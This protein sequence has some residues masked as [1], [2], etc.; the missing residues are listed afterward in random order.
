MRNYK[1][2]VKIENL[3]NK[4]RKLLFFFI[5]YIDEFA[6]LDVHKGCDK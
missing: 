3:E 5:A 1:V 4:F 2:T 6:N